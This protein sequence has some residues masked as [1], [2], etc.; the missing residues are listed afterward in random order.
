MVGILVGGRIKYVPRPGYVAPPAAV[1]PSVPLASRC[2]PAPK[3]KREPREKLPRTKL[4][5]TLLKKV[6]ELR[7]RWVEY[8]GEHEPGTAGLVERKY[9]LGRVLPVAE[10]QRGRGGGKALRQVA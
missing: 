9:R 7:D 4:D 5:P 6:R 10:G 1:A 3:P 2:L 8:A